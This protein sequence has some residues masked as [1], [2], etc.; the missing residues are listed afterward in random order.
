LPDLSESQVVRG[1]NA[2]RSPPEQRLK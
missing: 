2:E 1:D